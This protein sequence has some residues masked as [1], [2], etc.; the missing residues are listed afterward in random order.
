MAVKIPGFQDC[1]ASISNIA[2]LFGT[3]PFSLFVIDFTLGTP[4]ANQLT[5]F[6]A[7]DLLLLT[8]VKMNKIRLSKINITITTITKKTFTS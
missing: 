3:I 6:L 5:F 7:L 2:F 4:S 1:V 8:L